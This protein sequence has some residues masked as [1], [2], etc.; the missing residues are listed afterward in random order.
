MLVFISQNKKGINLCSEYLWDD[1]LSAYITT[2]NY[3]A[4]NGCFF[5]LKIKIILLFPKI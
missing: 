4:H 3:I 5:N 2:N 1:M